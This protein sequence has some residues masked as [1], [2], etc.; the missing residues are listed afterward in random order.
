MFYINVIVLLIAYVF[1][2]F[3]TPLGNVYYKLRNRHCYVGMGRMYINF[4]FFLTFFPAI[5]YI[6]ALINYANNHED[7]EDQ[8]QFVN[9]NEE[10]E[11]GGNRD[12]SQIKLQQ[13]Q[14]RNLIEIISQS[15]LYLFVLVFYKSNLPLFFK[16]N[17]LLLLV[18]VPLLLVDSAFGELSKSHT[19]VTNFARFVLSL[20]TYT[21]FLLRM[22][23][24][25]FMMVILKQYHRPFNLLIKIVVAQIFFRILILNV[26]LKKVKVIFENF[27]ILIFFLFV[28]VALF[29]K[30]FFGIFILYSPSAIDPVQRN[31]EQYTEENR[32]MDDRWFQ[33]KRLISRKAYEYE[34]LSIVSYLE[35]SVIL[36]LFLTCDLNEQLISKYIPSKYLFIFNICY[37]SLFCLSFI[38]F[39]LVCKFRNKNRR[40]LATLRN[41]D[42]NTRLLGDNENNQ[43]EQVSEQEHSQEIENHLII[44]ELIPSDVSSQ[45][46]SDSE[47]D[48]L[49]PQGNGN[50]FNVGN[51]EA[52]E[53]FFV[54]PIREIH[55]PNCLNKVQTRLI[56]LPCNHKICQFC[57]DL[58]KNSGF[59]CPICRNTFYLNDK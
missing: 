20:S 7:E 12:T 31:G 21:N 8:D 2:G 23:S 27:I 42:E 5:N 51:I 41:N 34:I 50:N 26:Y 35:N 22:I 9:I 40:M 25:Y 28:M 30:Y 16:I 59:G 10:E 38:L 45:L 11:G 6:I 57:L 3:V 43:Q 24:I 48:E 29:V 47:N 19:P 13:T 4:A 37:Y 53:D 18:S 56:S 49:V 58:A 44:E 15:F 54:Q 14:L 17:F 32:R 55:C 33:I 52:N 36:I 1:V 46:S 39:L